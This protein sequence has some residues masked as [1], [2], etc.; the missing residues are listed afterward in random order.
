LTGSATG[1]I[2][3]YPLGELGYEQSPRIVLLSDPGVVC[4]AFDISGSDPI[5]EQRSE[6]AYTQFKRIVAKELLA[7]SFCA[8][9]CFRFTIAGRYRLS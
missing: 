6:I 9:A 7:K 1:A 2:M 3:G 8:T 5:L 4:A